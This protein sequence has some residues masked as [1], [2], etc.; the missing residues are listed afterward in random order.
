[1]ITLRNNEENTSPLISTHFMGSLGFLVSGAGGH[2]GDK[3]V[4]MTLCGVVEVATF[5]AGSL[6]LA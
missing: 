4:T 5:C 3:V 6:Y 2:Y 1:M